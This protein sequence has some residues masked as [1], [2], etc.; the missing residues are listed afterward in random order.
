MYIIVNIPTLNFLNKTIK[1][2]NY[3]TTKSNIQRK[4][5]YVLYDLYRRKKNEC[6][7]FRE[8]TQQIY[9]NNI[10]SLKNNKTKFYLTI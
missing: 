1:L 4:I 8:K 10:T 7:F 9:L 2:N 5:S 3:V 6:V